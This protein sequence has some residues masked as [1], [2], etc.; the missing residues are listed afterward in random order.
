MGVRSLQYISG[1]LPVRLQSFLSGKKITISI[2]VLAIL[3]RLAHLIFFYTIGFDISY[4]VIATHNFVSENGIS[5]AKV[6]APDISAVV[7]E[8]LINWPP[9]YTLLQAPLYILFNKNYIASG[10]ILDMAGA[11][12]LIIYSRKIL[13]ILDVPL[14][15]INLF[16]LFTSFF[17]YPFYFIASTDSLA[18]SFFLIALFLA[19]SIIK[20]SSRIEK[21]TL[22]FSI[23]LLICGLLKY[24]FISLI[25]ILPTLLMVKGWLDRNKQVKI[26]GLA[27]FIALSLL[28][29]ILLAW[30]KNI[31]GAAV[32]ISETRRG[33]YPDHLLDMY[34]FITASFLNPDTI[35]LF[36]ASN[37]N[38]N[39]AARVL[40]R[41][42]T[43]GIF[44][45]FTARIIHY[46]FKRKRVLTSLYTVFLTISFS[47]T[48]GILCTLA[49]LSIRVH[50]EEIMPG[51]LWTY[52]QEPRYYGLAI[53]LIQLTFITFIAFYFSRLSLPQK[54][55]VLFF[56]LLLTAETT[57]GLSF[58]V[59]R[60]LQF[61]KETYYWQEELAFQQYADG[62]IQQEIKKNK[63]NNIA[64]TGSSHYRSN[65]IAVYSHIPV[66]DNPELVN[67]ISTI[68]SS[69]K[70]LLLVVI[71][72]NDRSAFSRFMQ[73]HEKNIAGNY[74]G[75]YFYTIYVNPA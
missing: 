43:S 65:H 54:G 12:V 20:N 32:F 64:V 33:F 22:V 40:F 31:S 51:Y 8:P 28:T 67:T 1:I 63:F 53:V 13:R 23:T 39:N 72:E 74:K 9:G 42:L 44:L 36:T 49:L 50:K 66:L 18:V 27:S 68:R 3:C 75:F 37:Q 5:I 56:S 7:Y 60:L 41:V 14:Y 46:V 58:T 2:I 21:R 55:F 45:Y 4:Q 16:T 70:S 71:H 73:Q 24:L 59:N 62:I 47:L 38:V 25:F 69:K 29:G 48:A 17:I 6:M 35:G 26:A 19:L 30:Q 61:S 52:I 11:L 57:R 15:Y 10:L 34:P